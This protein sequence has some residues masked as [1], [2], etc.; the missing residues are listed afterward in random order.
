MKMKKMK[1]SLLVRLL[2]GWLIFRKKFAKAGYILKMGLATG[3]FF[4][5]GFYLFLGPPSGNILLTSLG[6]VML[7][8]GGCLI[9]GTTAAL[10]GIRMKDLENMNVEYSNKF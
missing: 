9:L 6:V 5:M 7:F 10:K 8:I 1:G 4:S 2:L 3:C